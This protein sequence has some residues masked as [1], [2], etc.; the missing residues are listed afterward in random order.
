MP[1]QKCKWVKWGIL[2]LNLTNEK[3]AFSENLPILKTKRSERCW[4][5]EYAQNVRERLEKLEEYMNQPDVDIAPTL[6]EV[7][8]LEKK[9]GALGTIADAQNHKK[10]FERSLE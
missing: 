3:I 8:D 9:N 6:Q 7:V 2:D 1:N 5:D 4:K 10:D